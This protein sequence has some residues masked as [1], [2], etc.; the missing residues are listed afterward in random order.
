MR[1]RFDS[2]LPLNELNVFL[3]IELFESLILAPLPLLGR[4]RVLAGVFESG[5][6]PT[7]MLDMLFSDGP[8]IWLSLA[9]LKRSLDMQS[10]SSTDLCCAVMMLDMLRLFFSSLSSTAVSNFLADYFRSAT[11]VAVIVHKL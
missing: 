3:S 5:K 11:V 2:A 4:K 9:R 7:F 10:S 8:K 6:S 1:H